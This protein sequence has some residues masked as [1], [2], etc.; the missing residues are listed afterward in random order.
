MEQLLLKIDERDN[1]LVALKDLG[2]GVVSYKDKELSLK[3]AIP[4]KHKLL[5]TDL[6]KGDQVIMYGVPVGI[7]QKDLPS[8][9][10]LLMNKQN[11]IM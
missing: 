3:D 8:G 2:P 11:S 9:S 5:D 10:L 4:Q 1:V 7:V 6:A